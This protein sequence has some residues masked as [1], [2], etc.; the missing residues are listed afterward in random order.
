[1]TDRERDAA[2]VLRIQERDSDAMETIVRLYTA[3]VMTVIRGTAVPPL[4]AEDVEELTADVFVT[5]WQTARAVRDP[6]ALKGYL[7]RIA[8]NAARRA[9]KKH[10]AVLPLEDDILIAENDQPAT[11]AAL[12][13]QTRI[14]GEAVG[15]MPSVRRD[16]LIR[17]YFYDQPLAVIAAELSLP[18]S[19][20][21]THVYRGRRELIEALRE[22]GYA[23][24]EDDQSAGSV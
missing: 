6:F 15:A 3:Y 2:L 19:T 9:R 11:L 12:R 22:R 24:E 23:Y 4:S 1:M 14:V 10:R 18:L 17:R 16:C 20:V 7:S 5:L 8:R 21:K 13:E